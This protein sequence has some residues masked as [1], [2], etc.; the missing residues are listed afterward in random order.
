MKSA[1][2]I[3]YTS[4]SPIDLKF[5]KHFTLMRSIDE[6]IDTEFYKLVPKFED[7]DN[8][9]GDTE[10]YFLS[11]ADGEGEKKIRSD[12]R[13]QKDS[14]SIKQAGFNFREALPSLRSGHMSPSS[15]FETEVG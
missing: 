2:T 3:R 14:S 1:K 7:S 6:S 8:F 12:F 5:M 10:E 4:N 11:E 15:K 13:I 9:M